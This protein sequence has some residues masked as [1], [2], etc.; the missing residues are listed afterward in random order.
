MK[1]IVYPHECLVISTSCLGQCDQGPN[2]CIKD[3]I[4]HEC[5]DM[6]DLAGRLELAMEQYSNSDADPFIIEPK[7]VAASTVIE[8]AQN[9]RFTLLSVHSFN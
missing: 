5:N 4:L 1:D 9:G 8:K 6:I 3:K 2:I 7:L